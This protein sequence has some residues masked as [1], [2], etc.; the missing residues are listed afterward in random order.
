MRPALA[1]LA[2]AARLALGAADGI[3][4]APAQSC[5]AAMPNRC[6]EM[7]EGR[8]TRRPHLAETWAS[9]GSPPLARRCFLAR[10]GA[11]AALAIWPSRQAVHAAARDSIYQRIWDVDQSAS[12]LP[13]I[14][15]D[16]AGDPARGF[17]R[18]D[19]RGGRDPEHRCSPR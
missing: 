5:A 11:A 2:V 18:I 1:A 19:E 4:C 16:E 8:G 13:A 10:L 15:M 7:I 12:G 14:A 3:D 6:L 17:V 9:R